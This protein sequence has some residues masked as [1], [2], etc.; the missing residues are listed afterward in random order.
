MAVYAVVGDVQLAALEPLNFGDAELFDAVLV[1]AEGLRLLEAV[2]GVPGLSPGESL[3]LL[4]PE[5]DARLVRFEGG[6]RGGVQRV[7]ERVGGGQSHYSPIGC[8]H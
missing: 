8:W 6:V 2:R 4:L 1:E 5:R 7:G 3:R